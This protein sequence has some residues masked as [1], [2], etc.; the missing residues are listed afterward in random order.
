MN[1]S[2]N[3]KPL[4]DDFGMTI[5]NIRSPK[6]NQPTG[7]EADLPTTNLRNAPPPPR[8]HNQPPP[9]AQSIYDQ[10]DM[11]APN[12]PRQS[13]QNLP[14]SE[15]DFG[16][17]LNNFEPKSSA[18]NEPDFGATMSYIPMQQQPPPPRQERAE[19]VIAPPV[20]PIVQP[21][22]QEKKN[23]VPIWAWLLS[24]GLAFLAL[25]AV[26][27]LAAYFIFW[28]DTGFTLTIKGAPPGSTVFID[29]T[30]RGVTSADGSIK[31]FGIEADRKRTV[32]VT[33]EGFTDYNDTII[34]GNGETKELIAQ[35]KKTDTPPEKPK[36]ECTDPD[37][38][39]CKGEQA[40]L[41]ALDKLTP[42]FTVDQWVAAMN[43]QVINF[44]SNSAD[45]PPERKKVLEKG[46]EKFKLIAGNPGVEIGG[47]TDNVGSD[48]K[49][50][51]LS[52][53]RAQAVRFIL[54]N[55]GV[56]PKAFTTRGY[57]S[58]K[59]KTSNDTEEGKFQNRRIEYTV[60]SR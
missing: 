53:S 56:N 40:A 43:L 50:Q 51:P 10:F 3:P 44:A 42:P 19:T 28:R 22:K 24:G 35:M 5:P 21:A 4:P 48:A 39:V 33:H 46:A 31:I 18:Q 17:T 16:M 1:D 32:K 9:P 57:G 45:V 29:N 14:P 30:R 2:N 8:S 58:K 41:D 11:T 25:L 60:I 7:S 13:K 52:E 26:A 20:A 49:N 47:H 38:R 59:P 23:G 37:P 55:N 12:L 6:Q 15:T 27:G 34:G 54:V 36:T